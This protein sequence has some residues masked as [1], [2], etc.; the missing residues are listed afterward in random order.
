MAAALGQWLVSH[1]QPQVLSLNGP[2][3]AG[4]VVCVIPDGTGTITGCED[5]AAHA[6]HHL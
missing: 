1:C 3:N 2:E 4:I 5:D 6:R